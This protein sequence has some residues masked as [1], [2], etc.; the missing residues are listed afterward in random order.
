MSE[1]A[2]LFSQGEFETVIKRGTPLL[3]KYP[4]SAAVLNMVGLSNMRLRRFEK[5][6]SILHRAVKT[7][8]RTAAL[9]HNLGL[10]QMQVGQLE[11]ACV[12]L[13]KAVKLDPSNAQ[14]H[15]EL[16]NAHY[17]LGDI[18]GALAATKQA[19][20]ADPKFLAGYY[21]LGVLQQSLNAYEKAAHAFQSALKI[22]PN[23]F[24]AHAALGTVHQQ[25]GA[26]EKARE[27]YEAARKIQPNDPVN[28]CNFAA[29]LF[30][31]GDIGLART[32]L[33]TA[34]KVQPNNP[35]IKIDL[36]K[37]FQQEKRW[38]EAKACFRN[39]LAIDDTLIGAHDRLADSAFQSG[40]PDLAIEHYK[41]SMALAPEATYAAKRLG[42]LHT[43]LGDLDQAYS[44]F[45][46]ASHE[47]PSDVSLLM[48]RVTGAA[49]MADWEAEDFETFGFMEKVDEQ[50][51]SPLRL[52][53][54]DDSAQRQFERSKRFADAVFPKLAKPMTASAQSRPIRVGFISTNYNEHPVMDLMSGV[55]REH[56]RPNFS[57]HAISYAPFYD[58]QISARLK[59]NGVQFHDAS[60]LSDTAFIELVRGLALDIAIDMSGH[61]S[62]SN[63]ALFAHRLAPVQINYLAYPG[64]LGS[65]A[66]DYIVADPT[67]IPA[68]ATKHY[69]ENVLWM[70]GSYL[71]YDDQTPIAEDLPD[72]A[73]YG[74]PEQGFVFCSF[75]NPTKITPREFDVWMRLLGSIEDSCLWLTGKNQWV[76]SNLR[77]AAAKRNIDPAR[78]VFS[79]R[80]SKDEHLAR[81]QHA[82]LFL[83]TFNYNAHTTAIEA[84]WA[85]LP[86]VTKIGDQFAARVG[87]S[88]LN[89]LGLSDL[90]TS[91]E[92]EYEALT[93]KLAQDQDALSSV[94]DRLNNA[95]STSLVFDTKQYVRDFESALTTIWKRRV[96]GQ[97]PANLSI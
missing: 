27:S 20:D 9:Q 50:A 36:G 41:H 4:N 56:D 51:I 82:D 34:E 68:Q 39:A 47:D 58:P 15:L 49:K 72:R 88:L 84:L 24:H 12:T 22:E 67:V 63:S 96:S 46:H 6:N 53:F 7:S 38:T 81:H 65:E 35:Q 18:D 29:L 70:P 26:P 74:L 69:A 30:E 60:N 32:H 5:A 23:F 59:E 1:L 71:P 92:A 52:Q 89:G 95:R 11:D 76:V 48:D 86:L 25:C 37:C 57:Y 55:F 28:L 31:T 16:A 87:A 77:K 83:D 2:R 78:L 43:A 64:T 44:V 10:A 90:I 62:G 45:A 73:H 33:S 80:V 94:R 91:T 75:N 17:R 97:E 42:R 21:N 8:P 79:E 54:F 14:V 93:L 40:E 3:V 13:Q 19:V 66:F 61:T 85:G